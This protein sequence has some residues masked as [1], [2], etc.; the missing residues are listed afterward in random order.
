MFCV[1]V[2]ITKEQKWFSE[3]IVPQPRWN[4]NALFIVVTNISS[5]LSVLIHACTGDNF[6][7]HL[8]I[9]FGTY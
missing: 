9:H 5:L 8:F 4:Q 6:A 3:S 1:T 2:N 7:I